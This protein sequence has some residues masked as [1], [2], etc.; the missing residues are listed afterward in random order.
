MTDEQD[1][2]ADAMLIQASRDYN[3]PPIVPREEMWARIDAARRASAKSPA[4]RGWWIWPSAA[5]AAAVLM[6][7]GIGLGRR[8]E[9]ATSSARVAVANNPPAPASTVAAPDAD[10]STSLSYK[11][12][13]FK[14]LANSEALITAFRSAAKRGEVDDGLR[15]WSKE[16]LS[17]TRML[18]ASATA[19]DPTMKR[20][21]SDLD[22]VLTQIKLYTARGTND[23]DEL[24]LIE[25]SINSRGVI[26]KLRSTLPARAMPAGT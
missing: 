8:W 7:V 14:H 10:A 2:S 15:D 20:L 5:V 18:E 22:L 6:T 1:D 24:D 17:T 4:P 23:S 3:A 21:L 25:E 19:S 13:V 11:L 16:M 12:V 9:R 26:S